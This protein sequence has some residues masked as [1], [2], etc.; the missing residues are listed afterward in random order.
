MVHGQCTDV[1]V[2]GYLLGGGTNLLGATARHGVGSEHV[3]GYEVVTADGSI[4]TVTTNNVTEHVNAKGVLVVGQSRK[5]SNDSN[6]C[7]K[8]IC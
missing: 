1:G 5:I 3:L 4:I 7:S 8:Q 2:G 6:M